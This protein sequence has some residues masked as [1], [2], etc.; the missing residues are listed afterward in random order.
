MR[1]QKDWYIPPPDVL[2]AMEARIAEVD[3]LAEAT[4]QAIDLHTAAGYFKVPRP[5]ALTV[6]L[7]SRPV[8]V[9]VHAE[10]IARS[11]GAR[12]AIAGGRWLLL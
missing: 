1:A 7:T 5:A 2:D 3:G 10:N 8:A 9:D 4:A 12:Q 11:Y 6:C